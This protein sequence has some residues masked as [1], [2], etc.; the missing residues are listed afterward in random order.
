MWSREPTAS[1]EFSNGAGEAE[2]VGG[3]VGIERQ[4][5]AGQRAGTERRHVDRARSRRRSARRRGRAPSRGRAGDGRA[6]PAG[7]AAGACSRAG[8]R[9]RR[10]RRGRAA[11]PAGRRSARAIIAQLALAPQP[12]VGGDL[13]VAAATGVQL[14]ARRAG[15][16]GDPPLDG[17]VD[18]FVASRTN[19]NVPARSSSATVSS[20]ARIGVA[21][22][23]GDAVRRGPARARAPREPAMSSGHSRRSNDRLSVNAISSSAGPALEPAVPQRLARSARPSRRRLT[24]EP[25]EVAQRRRQCLAADLLVGDAHQRVV[26]GDGADQPGHGWSGRARRPRRARTR[27]ACAARPG[28]PSTAPRRPTRPS[29]AAGGPR[30]R[31]GPARTRGSRRRSR[32]R[33]RAPSPRRGPRGRATRSPASRAMPSSAEEVEQLRLAGDRRA[34]T[35]SLAISLLT[36]HLGGHRSRRLMRN[37]AGRAPRASGCGPGG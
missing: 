16:L 36:L 9:R 7:R 6:A 18:V 15:E 20:A 32:R 29:P 12:H 37:A 14:G 35:I 8:R 4:R 33:A 13:V 31:G 1:S 21:L 25:G 17:G 23:L 2:L 27:A 24:S 34:C 3:E 26:A 11:R 28:S 5:R 22:D 30:A 19:T 10:R